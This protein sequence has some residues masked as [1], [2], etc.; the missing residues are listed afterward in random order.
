[1][2]ETSVNDSINRNNPNITYVDDDTIDDQNDNNFDE[3]AKSKHFDYDGN[4]YRSYEDDNTN[5]YTNRNLSSNGSNHG[6][7]FTDVYANNNS[8]NNNYSSSNINNN[9]T[10]GSS[11]Y[12]NN[13]YS[14]YSNSYSSFVNPATNPSLGGYC[15]RHSLEACILCSLTNKNNNNNRNNSEWR[16]LGNPNPS[17]SNIN[18]MGSHVQSPNWTNS[19]NSKYSSPNMDVYQS[20][21]PHPSSS[22][23]LESMYTKTSFSPKQSLTKQHMPSSLLSSA[24]M[25]SLGSAG[26]L[27]SSTDFTSMSLLG[28][29]ACNQHGLSHCLL[30]SMNNTYN[31]RKLNT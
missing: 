7:S 15:E 5:N 11:G 10:P 27:A 23:M 29:D 12:S 13:N 17:S 25:A 30:C 19:N 28:D 24:S 20:N 14:G 18:H 6:S 8:Y 4:D 1:M 3:I 31:G 16:P 26:S 21:R 2:N 22:P 9:I